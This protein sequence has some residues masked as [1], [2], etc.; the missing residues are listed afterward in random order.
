MTR[1]DSVDMEALNTRMTTS[2]IRSGERLDSI[3]G[4]MLSNPSAAISIESEYNR[5]NPPKK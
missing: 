3:V 1:E 2:P 4:M 5:P